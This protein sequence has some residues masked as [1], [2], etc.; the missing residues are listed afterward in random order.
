MDPW[1]SFGFYG[2][3]DLARAP[4]VLVP[5]LQRCGFLPGL[6]LLAAVTYALETGALRCAA[7]LQRGQLQSCL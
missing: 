6:E 3:L 5:V 4:S 1:E 7:L 2:A